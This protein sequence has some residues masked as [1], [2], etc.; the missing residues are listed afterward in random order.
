LKGQKY[1]KTEYC[2][3]SI[4][5]TVER[6]DNDKKIVVKIKDTGIGIHLDVLPKLFY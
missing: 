4:G 2:Q 3:G 6:T 5:V 1:K